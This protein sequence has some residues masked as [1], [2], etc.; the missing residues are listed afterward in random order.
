MKIKIFFALFICLL[1]SSESIAQSRR[2]FPAATPT[3]EKVFP[4]LKENY[5]S[6]SSDEIFTVGK[7][8]G[9]IGK[10]EAL[11]LPKPFYPGEAKTD[12]A[13]GKIYVQ[14]SIDEKG[15]VVSAR[16]TEGHPALRKVAEESARS[17]KFRAPTIDNQP[18][19][20]RRLAGL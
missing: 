19:Q 18:R 9:D 8:T 6:A 13:E 4:V 17:S 1:I 12:S 15:N 11:Y 20:K 10:T 3:P 2:N 14:I 16:S 5:V 7:V